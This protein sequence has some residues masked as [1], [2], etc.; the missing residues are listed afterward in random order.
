[1]WWSVVGRGA[2]GGGRAVI[3]LKGRTC[4]L[5]RVLLLVFIAW[6]GAGRHSIASQ[7]ISVLFA[8]ESYI[9]YNFISDVEEWYSFDIEVRSMLCGTNCFSLWTRLERPARLTRLAQFTEV[10]SVVHC[11]HGV[12]LACRSGAVAGGR[13]C[14]GLRGVGARE[15]TCW[16]GSEA[17]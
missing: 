16:F 10:V 3:C 8:V 17:S 11:A 12:V 4:Y 13:A 9:E 14:E 6:T 7:W 2:G 1:M 5:V 15:G